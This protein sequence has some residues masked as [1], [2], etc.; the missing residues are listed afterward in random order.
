MMFDLIAAIGVLVILGAVMAIAKLF[1]K[2]LTPEGSRK[3]IHIVMGCTALAF[4][5]IF[6]YKQSVV[7]LGIAAISMLMFLRRNEFLRKR[8]GIALLGVQR[9]TLGDIYFVISIVIVFVLHQSTFE[10][11]I[12]IAVLTFADSIAAL[13]G[14]TYGRYNMAQREEETKSR[15]GS[16]MFFIV[17]FICTLIPLQLMSEVG[18]TEVLVISFLIGILAAIIEAVTRKGNDNLMLPILTY[19]ILKYNIEQPLDLIFTNF[20]IMLFLLIIVFVVYKLTNISRLSI[21]YTMLV[22]Y[23]IMILGGIIW[24]LPPLALLLTFGI[25]PMMGKKEKNMVQTYKVIE[26]NTIVGVI[27]LVLTGFFPDYRDILYL[28]FSLSF[29]IHL[30]NN[31]CRRLINFQHSSTS[32]SVTLGF[33]KAAVF[34]VLPVLAITKM[35]WLIFLMYLIFMAIAMPFAVSL[36]KKHNYKKV[37]EATF[38][39]NKILIGGWVA[40]FTLILA[41]INEYYDLFR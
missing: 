40:V 36:N 32:F 41:I 31:T 12:P 6:E 38:D 10:Y 21:A 20:G 39:I 28:S 30:A 25:L 18:R 35:D 29:A 24:M 11:L 15:E 5:Y 37:G 1:Y 4:P 27:C 23:I 33:V 22:G 16:V 13:V 14:V 9:K 3:T 34:I 8:I 17:A 19:S 7:Y 2:H 26:Y